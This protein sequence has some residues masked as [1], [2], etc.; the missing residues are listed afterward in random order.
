[1]SLKLSFESEIKYGTNIPCLSKATAEDVRN[2]IS[3][4]AKDEIEVNGKKYR[5][6]YETYPARDSHRMEISEPID[7]C[8]SKGII[9]ITKESGNFDVDDYIGESNLWLAENPNRANERQEYVDKI[10][11]SFYNELAKKQDIESYKN[12]FENAVKEK[13]RSIPADMAYYEHENIKTMEEYENKRK[14]LRNEE[15]PLKKY[16]ENIK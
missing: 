8:N 13:M 14:R 6:G 7:E 11:K 4:V 10:F 2:G 3:I 16:F 5:I 9:T 15:D 12:N 1:M